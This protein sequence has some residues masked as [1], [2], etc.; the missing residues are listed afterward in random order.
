MRIQNPID[1]AIRSNQQINLLLLSFNSPEYIQIHVN[2]W[3]GPH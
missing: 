3:N 2:V 1:T